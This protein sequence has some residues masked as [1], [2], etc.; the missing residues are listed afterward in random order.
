MDVHR[1]T[2]QFEAS[3]RRVRATARARRWW[4][5]GPCA[6][7]LAHLK[8]TAAYGSCKYPSADTFGTC[9]RPSGCRR[10][11]RAARASWL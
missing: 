4:L 10:E 7:V 8:L 2:T 1:A 5:R 3:G 11:R 9:H 6:A